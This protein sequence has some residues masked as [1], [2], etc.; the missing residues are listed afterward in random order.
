MSYSPN[1]VT[2]FIL[3]EL[4]QNA[5]LVTLT[6][7]QYYTGLLREPISL[8]APYYTRIG[9]EYVSESGD[10]IFFTQ[11]RDYDLRKVQIKFTIVTSYGNN[12]AH[13]RQLVDEITTLF[14]VHRKKTEIEY[15]IYIDN[16]NSSIV[17]TE[18]ARW[19]GT[20]TLDV[21][22]LTLIPEGIE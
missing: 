21:S 17:E 7:N 22:Y 5:S 18:Q 9:I 12:D 10:G 14:S 19:V 20:I 4:H 1:L 8:T 11:I 3:D 6:N 15:K 13:C 2:Q 16:I